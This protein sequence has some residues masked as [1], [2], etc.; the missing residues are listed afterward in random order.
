[1]VCNVPGNGCSACFPSRK[2]WKKYLFSFCL[3]S[4]S[5]CNYIKKLKEVAGKIIFTFFVFFVFLY[6]FNFGQFALWAFGI[7]YETEMTSTHFIRYI[8][9]YTALKMQVISLQLLAFFYVGV[10]FSQSL[11]QR[12]SQEKQL[13]T[14]TQYID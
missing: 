13:I 6:I 4:G 1:M 9:P 7:H 11:R 14:E 5:I 8:D 2:K 3:W 10:L 12:K